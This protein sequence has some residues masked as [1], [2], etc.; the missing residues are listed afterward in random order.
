MVGYRRGNAAAG[1]GDAQFADRLRA[2]MAASEGGSE[3]VIRTG[4]L[5]RL[6]LDLKT[7]LN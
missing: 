4:L 2:F 3:K 7:K 1:G 6:F 5:S